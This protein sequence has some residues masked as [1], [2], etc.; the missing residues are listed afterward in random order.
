MLQ[1]TPELVAGFVRATL[2]EGE[3]P[4][5]STMRARRA[6]VRVLFAQLRA[7]GLQVGDPTL[8]LAVPGRR[9][10]GARPLSDEEIVLGRMTAQ[11]RSSSGGGYA[12]VGWALAEAGAVSSEIARVRVADLDDP[13]RPGLVRLPGT[14]RL[15]GR[16]AELT[17]WGSEVLAARARALRSCG[18]GQGLLAY[19]GAAPPGAAVSQ[20]AICTSMR[21]VL[22]TAG[23]LEVAGEAPGDVRPVSVRH[24][25]GR[26]RYDAGMPLEAV[27]RWLGMRSLDAAAYDLAIDWREAPEPETVRGAGG[28]G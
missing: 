24:W 25:A 7:Q 15:D 23:L 21:A 26:R 12:S 22:L 18:R 8:D 11:L 28:V 14:R 16:A 2:P 19:Q 13:D 3:S 17:G 1:V 20:S 5:A 4:S 9:R 10:R 6:A 27:A